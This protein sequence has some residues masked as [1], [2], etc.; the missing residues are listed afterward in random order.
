MHTKYGWDLLYFTTISCYDRR[1]VD[2]IRRYIDIIGNLLAEH[3][4]FNDEEENAMK[5]TM[6]NPI[7]DN[8]DQDVFGKNEQNES[9]DNDLWSSQ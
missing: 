6:S 4:I 8:D 9:S 5:D 3:N 1:H 2:I 7:D